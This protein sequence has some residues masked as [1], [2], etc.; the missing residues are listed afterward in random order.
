MAVQE[1]SMFKTTMLAALTVAGPALAQEPTTTLTFQN[2]V[3]TADG[4]FEQVG[5]DVRKPS[6]ELLLVGPVGRHRPSRQETRLSEQERA[7]ADG[8]EGRSRRVLVA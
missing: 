6:L 2:N 3:A 1:N 7:L 5:M 8:A 4:Y